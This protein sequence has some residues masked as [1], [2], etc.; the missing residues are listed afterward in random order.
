MKSHYDIIEWY[1][2]TGLRPYLEMLSPDDKEE[3][4]KDI[5]AEVEKAYPVQANGE[6]IFRFPR[7]FVK[8]VR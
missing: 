4:E 5:F 1:R 8:A 7:L 2:A 6:I 3:F